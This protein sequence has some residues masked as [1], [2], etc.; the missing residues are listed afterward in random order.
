MISVRDMALNAAEPVARKRLTNE[1][2]AAFQRD[3]FV[4]LPGLFTEE[5]ISLLQNLVQ[6]DPAIREHAVGVI[7]SSGSPSELF[8]WSGKS[9]DIL[10][11]FIS[12]ARLVESAQDLLEGQSV[13]HWHSKLSFKRP[14]SE[15]RW[16]WHQ[17]YASWYKEGCLRPEMLTAMVAIDPCSVENGCVQLVRGSNQLG[18]IEH[19]PLGLSQGA[20][21]DVVARALDQLDLVACELEPG[22]VVFFHGNTLHAS[23]PNRSSMPRTIFHVSYNTERNQPSNPL[24]I[25]AYQPLEILPDA[26]LISGD[27][28]PRLDKDA[29][30]RRHEL[31]R[32]QNIG[33]VYGYQVDR[34]IGRS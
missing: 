24:L 29:L 26:A 27:F 3:G 25:H 16:D 11:A 4:F 14:G 20:D 18:R 17:D 23:G 21:P 32:R 30:A 33:E 10:G 31:R 22:D 9:D 6:G 1:Q 12:I 7:D 34:K 8:G 19:G 5:E 28:A 13:Y 2:V 15:G